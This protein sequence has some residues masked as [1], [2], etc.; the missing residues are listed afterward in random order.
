MG[1]SKELAQIAKQL[2]GETGDK[3]TSQNILGNIKRFG[4]LIEGYNNAFENSIRLSSYIAAR[5]KGI[6][7]EKAAQFAKT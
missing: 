2:E 7:R 5:Q 3:T 6:T 4:E 1:I